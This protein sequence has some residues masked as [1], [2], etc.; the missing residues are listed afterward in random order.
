MK[1][2]EWKKVVKGLNRF[3]SDHDLNILRVVLSFKDDPNRGGIVT[4]CLHRRH[5]DEYL[6]GYW[7]RMGIVKIPCERIRKVDV[8]ALADIVDD[9]MRVVGGEA[10]KVF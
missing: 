6:E 10:E 8:P 3:E 4:Y 7:G 1:I 9:W 2:S 5:T